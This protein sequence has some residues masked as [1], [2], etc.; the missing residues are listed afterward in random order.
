MLSLR[1]SSCSFGWVL[2]LIG[3]RDIIVNTL[4]PSDLMIHLRAGDGK[5]R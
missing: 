5:V 1:I 4:L 3:K 2:V